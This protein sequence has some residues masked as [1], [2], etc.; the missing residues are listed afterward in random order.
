[1]SERLTIRLKNRHG[2][3]LLASVLPRQEQLPGSQ[4]QRLPDQA[5]VLDRVVAVVN[6]QA[7]LASDVND[8]FGWRFWTPD[9]LDSAY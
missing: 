5:V 3:A 1:M 4:P 2:A 6:N 9:G 7:I 8:E